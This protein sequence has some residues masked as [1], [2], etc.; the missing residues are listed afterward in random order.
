M[1]QLRSLPPEARLAV[2]DPEIPTVLES[3]TLK[4]LAAAEVIGADVD[5]LMRLRMAVATSNQEDRAMYLCPECFVPLSIVCRKDCRSF[6]F[7]HTLED[8]R[9]SAVTRGELTREEINARKYNGAKESVLHRQMK[10]WLVESLHAS[11]MF[12]EIA[13][14]RRWNGP[15]SGAWRRPDVSAKLGSVVV[16][17]EVQLSTTFLGVIAER[18]SFYLREGGLLFWVFANFNEDGRRLTMDDVFYNNNQNAFIVSKATC[19]ES[20]ATGRFVLD[21]AWVEPGY[22]NAAPQFRRERVA[23]D[24]LTLDLEKQQAYFFNYAGSVAQRDA[25]ETKERASWPS[26]FENWWLDVANRQSSLADQEDELRGFP[27]CAPRDWNDWGMLSLTPLRFYGSELRLPIA[28]LDCFY[29]AKHG[30]PIGIKRKH[31]IEIAHY[32]AES[33]PRYLL[34]FRKALQVYERGDLL[35]KQ[36]KSGSWLKR[37]KAYKKDM[38][39][40]PERYGSDQRHQMLF[41]FL[42]PELKPLPEWPSDVLPQC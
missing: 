22:W 9:C 30:R 6:W 34:W 24:E 7:K 2:S 40:N 14:E 35:V 26:R 13:Q 19:E 31:L 18:R 11:G 4:E 36:D 28:M 41:E 33:Y 8:G 10:Q 15:V 1:K 38:R 16:A 37:V 3:S 21:C 23:F 27:S 20:R 42:F 12:T 25:D 32:L 5:R 39:M 17:F 29:S